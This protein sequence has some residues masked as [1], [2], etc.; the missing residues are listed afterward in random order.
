MSEARELIKQVLCCAGVLLP[1]D[2]ELT[3]DQRL[4]SLAT[5]IDAALGGLTQKWRV[6]YRGDRELLNEC[7]EEN[8][9][10]CSAL[11][12]KTITA[13]SCW[14]SDW[15]EV[16]CVRSHDHREHVGNA[17][18]H[19]GKWYWCET[20]EYPWFACD[21]GGW[22]GKGHPGQSFRTHSEAMEYAAQTARILGACHDR[23]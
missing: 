15:T 11:H 21:R 1:N 4:D 10:R 9:R 12:P 17:P 18:W 7:K 23:P 16:E 6:H 14:V 8:A 2:W 5:E 19:V 20:D 13:E 22:F 3:Y